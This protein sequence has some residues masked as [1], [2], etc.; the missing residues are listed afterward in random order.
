LEV[1]KKSLVGGLLIFKYILYPG[2]NLNS[3]I[4]VTD[5]FKGQLV[6]CEFGVV[7]CDILNVL[8][9]LIFDFTML[10]DHGFLGSVKVWNTR[11]I[12]NLQIVIQNRF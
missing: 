1:Q 10:I 11:T 3:T 8:G 9:E 4:K 7:N 6:N 12:Q 5:L 2:I